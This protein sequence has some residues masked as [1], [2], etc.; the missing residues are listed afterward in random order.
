MAKQFRTEAVRL[1]P[2]LAPHS[3]R[4]E[5][6]EHVV[7]HLAR[8]TS[9]VCGRLDRPQRCAHAQ[10]SSEKPR[11]SRR[12]Q[13]NPNGDCYVQDTLLRFTSVLTPSAT[14]QN[15]TNMRKF[16]A[17]ASACDPVP[18]SN[19]RPSST[20]RSIC[21]SARKSGKRKTV[22]SYTDD[23]QSIRKRCAVHVASPQQQR[24]HKAKRPTRIDLSFPSGAGH[25][26]Q[27]GFFL[28]RQQTAPKEL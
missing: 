13:G 7:L 23:V 22:R 15:F 26:P 19:R 20:R 14:G 2:P 3:R 9:S 6:D 21:R 28:R 5:M 24:S 1:M 18:R 17:K 27:S 25:S 16:L 10:C 4:Q 12:R 8:H 11:N